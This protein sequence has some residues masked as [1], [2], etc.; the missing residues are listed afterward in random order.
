MAQAVNKQALLV[1]I[2]NYKG[3]KNDLPRSGLKQDLAKMKTLFESWGFTVKTLDEKNS[4]NV[5]NVLTGYANN[6]SEK[7][8]FIYYYNGHGASKKDD[9]FDEEDGQDEVFI[10]S[11]GKKDTLFVDDELNQYL[12]KIKARKLILFD[13][14]HSGTANKGG[15]GR[16]GIIAKDML[17]PAEEPRDEKTVKRQ[18]SVA[19][20]VTLNSGDFIVLSAANDLEKALAT[21]TGS[22]FSTKFYELLSQTKNRQMSLD[23]VRH[24]LTR[25]IRTYCIRHNKKRHRPQLS[26]PKGKDI[27]KNISLKE[28]L[29]LK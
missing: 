15:K 5:R 21:P 14:C 24:N 25:K 2:S 6:L 8:I 4:L 17:L 18:S 16:D 26:V 20:D 19:E 12:N 22:V 27:L 10:L 28:Y 7:D 29:M 3:S 23:Q 11:D 9:G 13:S 1:G